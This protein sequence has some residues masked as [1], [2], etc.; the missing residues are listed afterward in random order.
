MSRFQDHL[1][2]LLQHPQAAKLIRNPEVQRLAVEVLRLRGRLEGAFEERVQRVA[3][4]LSLATQR[5]LRALQRRIRH[6][7]HELRDT[8]ERLTAAEDAREAR[9]PR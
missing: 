1:F 6:L 9:A 7:E 3:G 2:R 4:M 5:D 8:E